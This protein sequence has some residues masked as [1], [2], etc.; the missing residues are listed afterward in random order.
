L[1]WLRRNS[2]EASAVE[3]AVV[4]HAAPSLREAAALWR[5]YAGSVGFE[6]A[7]LR[8]VH[9][10]IERPSWLAA[11]AAASYD[12][13]ILANALNELYGHS[14]DPL[15]RRAK[16]IGSLLERLH[17]AGA[18]L[19]VEPALRET[20]RNLHSLRDV[21]LARDLCTVY[22]PCLHENSCPALFKQEDWCH[23]ERPWS[24]PPW[25][26]AIDG[27]AALIKDALKF[28]YVILRRD[29]RTIV[30][31]GETMFR[32][33]SELRVMKGD[34]RA[35]LCSG[36]GRSDVGRLDRERSEANQSVDAWHRGAI[37]RLTDVDWKASTTPGL[38]TGRVRKMSATEILRARDG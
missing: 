29:G 23:E 27:V 19:I 12:V 31:R 5:S 13:I 33:V 8:C 10:D 32:V 21:L 24:A 2:T 3:A 16:L 38:Q 17:P 28:S 22:S 35:W 15:E 34:V 1:D 30:P 4:D 18:L 36:H 20:S 7:R 9:A 37:V 25:I 11:E 26:D 14:S 6:D